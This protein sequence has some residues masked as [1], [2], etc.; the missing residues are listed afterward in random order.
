MT[1]ATLRPAE[2]EI[3]AAMRAS[4]RAEVA[5][6]PG[7]SPMCPEAECWPRPHAL[8]AGAR[9]LPRTRR[10]N[11]RRQRAR[12]A[13]SSRESADGRVSRPARARPGSA[14]SAMARGAEE[15]AA[16][17]GPGGAGS[18]DVRAK[19]NGPDR[20]YRSR[21]RSALGGRDLR[22]PAQRH[23]RRGRASASRSRQRAVVLARRLGQLSFLGSGDPCSAWQPASSRSAFLK[24]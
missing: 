8:L 19:P 14:S 6:R 2:P 15:V 12:P 3:R 16:L 20:Q 23:R 18:R 21:R 22:K 1:L 7:R 13:R 10:R 17:A 24:P 11:P 9:P 4:I 5:P